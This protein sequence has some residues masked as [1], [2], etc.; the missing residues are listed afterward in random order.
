PTG[1]TEGQPGA[2]REWFVTVKR[3]F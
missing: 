1:I 3:N 2:P